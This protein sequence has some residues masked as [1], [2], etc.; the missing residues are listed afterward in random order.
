ML[1]Q[2][3]ILADLVDITAIQLQQL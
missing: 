1:H 2:F 3:K